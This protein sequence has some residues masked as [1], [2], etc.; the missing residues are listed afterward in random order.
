VFDVRELHDGHQARLG[1]VTVTT[2][3]VEHGMPAFAARFETDAVALTY[4]G[5]TAPC[6]ALTDLARNCDRLLCEADSDTSPTDEPPLH[7]AP[8]DAGA[9]ATASKARRLLITHI[10]PRL[11]PEDAIGRA[12]TRFAGRIDYAA[13]GRKFTVG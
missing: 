4:S 11:D 2:R 3:A 5:D 1:P 7:H 12:A 10:G 8:E 9:T 13:A 6:A